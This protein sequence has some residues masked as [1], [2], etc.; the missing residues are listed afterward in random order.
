MI[1]N[2]LPDPKATDPALRQ[3]H[4]GAFVFDDDRPK[5]WDIDAGAW[6]LGYWT[7]DWSDEVIRI[8]QYDPQQKVIRLAAPHG[9]GLKGG[10]WGSSERRFFAQNILEELDSP[11]EWYLDRGERKLYFY[12]IKPLSESSVILAT[13]SAPLVQIGVDGDVSRK[14]LNSGMRV[15]R[16]DPAGGDHAG[17]C[18]RRLSHHQKQP[19]DRHRRMSAFQYRRHRNQRQWRRDYDSIL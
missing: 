13:Q 14:P 7:H 6:L 17:V 5:R 12:P 18:S 2:G 8:A 16:R 19:R 1:D 15:C 9:Y 4:P 11:G 10:T 3:A